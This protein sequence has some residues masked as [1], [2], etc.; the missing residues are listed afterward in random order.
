MCFN[1]FFYVLSQVASPVRRAEPPITRS[2][3]GKPAL[4]PH[5]GAL[6]ALTSNVFHELGVPASLW[7]GGPDW[8]LINSTPNVT[9]FE[10]KLGAGST[11]WRYNGRSV[12]RVLESG[13]VH[14]G[15]FGGF[16]DLFV[17]VLDSRNGRSVL[18]VGPLALARPTSADI[19]ERWRT[20][21]GEHGRV[22]EPRFA[23]YVAATLATL[24]L[25]GKRL[26]T[27]RTLV[28]GFA[29][30]MAHVGNPGEVFAAVER[31][32]A[33]LLPL[34]RAESMWATAKT[35][36]D[37]RT[38]EVW[39][40][41]SEG[42]LRE[43][44]L[45][46]APR[47][48]MVGLVRGGKAGLDPVD[49]LIRQDALQR[50]A[51]A[52]AERLGG[53]LCG[54]LGERGFSFLVEAS[55]TRARSKS[56]LAELAARAVALGR[57][58]GLELHAG[59]F[60]GRERSSLSQT[61]RTALFAAERAMTQ[62]VAVLQGEAGNDQRRDLYEERSRLAAAVRENPTLL[63][64]RFE[65]YIELV[66]LRSGYQLER[67]RADLEAGF[68]RLVEPLLFV[69]LLSDRERSEILLSSEQRADEAENVMDLVSGYRRAALEIE[70]LLKN[71]VSARHE[72]A[73]Q[74]AVEIMQE[75]HAEPLSV[76]EIAR[77]VGFAPEYFS[78]LFKR[79]EGVPPEVYL[80]RLRLRHAARML[81]ASKLS[82]E[83]IA[84]LCGFGSRSYFH[85]AFRRAHG[86]T[87]ASY[88][89]RGA[90][91]SRT[92]K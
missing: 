7:L 71:A 83:G 48:V 87:P 54:R 57:Q 24:T 41:Y 15:R 56:R 42:T 28:Q 13:V 58:F 39:L 35:M 85:H 69:D 12:D 63:S 32:R 90:R 76:S 62:G 82:V 92:K 43:F 14:L 34:R 50:A 72:R 66:L 81:E 2:R 11:R 25:E 3:S 61:Y 17:P 49:A 53:V 75:R 47:G 33:E 52:L 51:V 1:L 19:L 10:V 38:G 27:F 74:R 18:I 37:E 84:K 30:L 4:L 60:E 91:R 21:T 23:S 26:D 55:R 88:R 8:R 89:E 79:D 68:E 16:V 59:C 45:K 73:T 80:L 46:R 40:S 64:A 36:L 29:D 65:R 67:T 6:A 5:Q 20:I 78:K 31:A 77:A 70:A 9:D 22:T 44:G 86:V